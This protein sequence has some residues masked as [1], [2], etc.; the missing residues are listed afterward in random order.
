MFTLDTNVVLYFLKGRLVNP[1]PI[2]QYFMSIITEIELL[3]YPNLTLQE[4][5]NIYSFGEQ[6]SIVG[7]EPEIKDVTIKLRK[8][9]RL[10]LPDAVIA[11]TAK[12]LNATLLTNDTAL[13]NLSEITTQSVLIR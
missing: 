1:L 5:A 11:A 10:K 7:I 13:L 3:S 4:E 6:V 9:Y 8:N 12:Y 2:G